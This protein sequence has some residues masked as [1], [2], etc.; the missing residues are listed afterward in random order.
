MDANN[1]AAPAAI[2]GRWAVAAI[3]FMNGFVLG[4]W[5]PQIPVLLTR[6]QITRIH[7]RLAAFACSAPA[8]S[9]R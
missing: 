3:F 7:A 9:A 1:A 8:R 5:A 2:R 6:L 4:S